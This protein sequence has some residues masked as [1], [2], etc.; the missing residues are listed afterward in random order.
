MSLG[1]KRMFWLEVKVVYTWTVGTTQLY[2]SCHPSCAGILNF[3]QLHL[4]STKATPCKL[5]YSLLLCVCAKTYES[6]CSNH[7]SYC[8]VALFAAQQLLDDLYAKLKQLELAVK[9][10]QPD[11]AGVRVADCLKRVANLELLQVGWP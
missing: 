8:H 3:T 11:F 2:N 9:T 6:Q 1:V 7:V 4:H 10:Q 5:L